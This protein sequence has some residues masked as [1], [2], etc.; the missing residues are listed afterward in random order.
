MNITIYSWSITRE[1]PNLP[2]AR[3]A[4]ARMGG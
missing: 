1:L 4:A 2:P 3:P